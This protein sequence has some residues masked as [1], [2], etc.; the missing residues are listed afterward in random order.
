MLYFVISPAKDMKK[1][2]LQIDKSIPCFIDKSKRLMEQL[3]QF[4]VEEMKENMRISEKLALLNKQRFTEFRFDNKGQAAIDTYYGLQYK[5]LALKDYDQ[6]MLAYMNTHIRILSG[7]YGVLKPFDSIY[8]YR[9]EM[10]FK[11]FHLY[12]FWQQNIDEYFKNHTVINLA[13]QE[14]GC[15]LNQPNVYHVVFYCRKKGKLVASS[16]NVKIARGK[17]I[18]YLIQHKVENFHEIKQFKE[19]GY[20]FQKM[21]GNTFMFI[22]EDNDEESIN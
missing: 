16:T 8:C 11:P 22:K 6:K 7:L 15:L 1:S 2:D 10:K 3:Q 18:D 19:D 12:D 20:T 5:Q 4:S 21:S 9:L 17:F 13:S 14:Y